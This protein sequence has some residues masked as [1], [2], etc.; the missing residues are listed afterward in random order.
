MKRISAVPLTL[1]LFLLLTL[2][3]LAAAQD[4]P[5]PPGLSLSVT[6]GMDSFYKEEHWLPVHINVANNG[7]SFEGTLL[8][9]LGSSN[10]E[11]NYTAPVS[12]PNQSN[13]RVTLYISTPG[14]SNR[15]TIHLLN[16]KGDQIAHTQ[17]QTLRRV[18]AN[19]LLYGVLSPNGDKLSFLERVKGGRSEA[20]VA[21]LTLANL[22]DTAVGWE[23]LDILIVHDTDLSQMT[24]AQQEALDIWISQGG[25]LVVAGG[26]G[27][28]KTVTPLADYLP[29]TVNSSQSIN[30]LPGLAAR[31]GEP[32]RDPGPYLL[33]TSSLRSGEL[34]WHE[35]GMP[36]LA[37][38]EWGRGRVYF[39][40]LDP[41]LAP[42]VD[43]AGS[44][45][46][47]DNIAAQVP[48]LPFWAAGFG[49]SYAASRAVKNIPT[50]TLPSAFLLLCF[51]GFYVL[52]IGPVNY[53]TLKRLKRREWAWISIPALIILFTG[54]AYITGFGLK[55]NKIILHQMNVAYGQANSPAL[56]VNSLV[57]LYSP[58][59]ASYDLRLPGET[60]VLPFTQGFNPT[61]IGSG[62]NVQAVE[63][64]ADLI[65]RG[66]RVDVSDSETFMVKSY[67]PSPQ[68]TSNVQ[69]ILRDGQYELVVTL[70]NDGQTT[71]KNAA[72][73]YGSTVRGLGDLA[74]GQEKSWTS[75]LTASQ[76]T[77]AGAT[78]FSGYSS[79]ILN[80][81]QVILGTNNIN[82]DPVAYSRRQLLE[83]MHRDI[84]GSTGSVNRNVP[85]GV[86]TLMGWSEEP[87]LNLAVL[88]RRGQEQVASTLYFLELPMNQVQVS[89][90]D[91]T[92]PLSMLSWEII[93]NSGQYG[94]DNTGIENF[95]LRN[96]YIEYEFQPAPTFTGL[97]VH[98]VQLTLTRQGSSG[99]IPIV[100][101]WNWEREQW[102]AL[103][104]DSWGTFDIV[105]P[106]RFLGPGNRIRLRLETSSFD[107]GIR[108]FHPIII[109]NMD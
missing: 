102:Q 32:F 5:L 67:Q 12:L 18:A 107:I 83:A 72:L 16:D 31:A 75:R 63:R 37:R 47:W 104:I 80:N 42:L 103:A 7:P 8:I 89:G 39:L 73:L 52:L 65:V 62:W 41:T 19:D 20:K 68:I 34:L 3:P 87:L 40:A 99:N 51:M 55:G 77:A 30:D 97:N 105:N 9:R 95:T 27:W 50:L 24:A 86:V 109:G 90:R 64:G 66:V 4:D 21:L 100:N 101:A 76:A 82:N 94:W 1:L 26:T 48:R 54:C 78:S 57:A 15:F 58:R 74:P 44:P 59:R 85:L 91:I 17:T 96:G 46:I 79:P 43:W 56:R 98:T 38:R 108:L 84:Y 88:S 25:Q 10:N 35:D 45:L 6:A 61:G 2:A 81:N 33:T 36:L 92:V 60:M 23:M 106:E 69:L 93:G 71:L 13:K 22:P 28:Q 53:L 14:L 70:R 29:V 11:Q 49:N